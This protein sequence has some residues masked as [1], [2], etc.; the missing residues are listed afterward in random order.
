[1]SGTTDKIKGNVKEAAGK[2]TG[3][4]RLE[5]EGKAD[6]VKGEA[7]KATQDVSEAAKGVD[8]S[9]KKG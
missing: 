6:Q 7:K 4:K 9:L 5:G 2:M 1:M 3:D 8:D